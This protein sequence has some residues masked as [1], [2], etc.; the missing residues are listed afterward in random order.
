MATRVSIKRIY[1]VRIEI[2]F[3]LDPSI[4]FRNQIQ[5]NQLN[6]IYN[7]TAEARPFDIQKNFFFLI[8]SIHMYILNKIKAEFKL[9]AYQAVFLDIL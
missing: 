7:R 8:A 2:H 6:Y 9:S 4:E 5:V 3:V 1:E